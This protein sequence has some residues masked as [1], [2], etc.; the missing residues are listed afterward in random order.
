MSGNLEQK[1]PL[2]PPGFPDLPAIMGLGMVAGDAGIKH[3]G[4][5]DLA[6]WVLDSGTSAAG[7]FTRS[8]LPAAPIT[9][10]KEHIQTAPPRALVVKSLVFTT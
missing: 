1:S 7:L 8:V 4:R 9:V 6:I 2:A 10:T 5:N 3:A